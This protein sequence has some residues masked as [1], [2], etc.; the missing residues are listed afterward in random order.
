MKILSSELLTH[1][2]SGHKA[3]EGSRYESPEGN[4]DDVGSLLRTEA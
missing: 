2:A 3:G 4:T 1:N